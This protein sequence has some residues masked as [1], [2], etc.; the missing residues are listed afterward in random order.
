MTLTGNCYSFVNSVKNKISDSVMPIVM[1]RLADA[2]NRDFVKPNITKAFSE[3]ENEFEFEP[4]GL[5]RGRAT[6][7]MEAGYI[8]MGGRKTGDGWESDI[9]N[10]TATAEFYEDGGVGVVERR[11]LAQ[12]KLEA[13]PRVHRRHKGDTH[14]YPAISVVEYTKENN[15]GAIAVLAIEM[16]ELEAGKLNNGRT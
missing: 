5:H 13:S 10:N 8:A 9:V 16:F 4:V 7:A 14:D 2:V 15:E 12:H 3:H 1:T 6:G 11:F